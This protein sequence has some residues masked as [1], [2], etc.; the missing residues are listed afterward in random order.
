M[1]AVHLLRNYSEML[2]GEP[3]QLHMNGLLKQLRNL[4]NI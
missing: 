2:F 4:C 3:E 1:E